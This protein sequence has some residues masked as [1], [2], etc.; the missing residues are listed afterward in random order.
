[1]QNPNPSN[2]GGI[3]YSLPKQTTEQ[4][5]AELEKAK[6]ETALIRAEN[7]RL[8]AELDRMKREEEE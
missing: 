1:M 5:T 7:Y 2:A 3:V 4:L 6:Q 8:R